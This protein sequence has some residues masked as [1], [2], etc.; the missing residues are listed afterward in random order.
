MTRPFERPPCPGCNGR[1]WQ[2]RGRKGRDWPGPCATC[3][4]SGTTPTLYRLAKHLEED[5]NAL[6]RLDRMCVGPALASRLLDK[7]HR[8]VSAQPGPGT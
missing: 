2:L 6:Y 3:L 7:L 1:G 4:G 8:F 5:P